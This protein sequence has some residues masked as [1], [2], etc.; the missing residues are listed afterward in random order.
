M[1]HLNSNSE[2]WWR[3][4]ESSNCF[5][6]SIRP[7]NSKFNVLVLGHKKIWVVCCTC[8]SAKGAISAD[9]TIKFR[10]ID[11]LLVQ[12]HCWV[13][14]EE[15]T[16]ESSWRSLSHSCVACQCILEWFE[17]LLSFDLTLELRMLDAWVDMSVDSLAG[18]LIL[19]SIGPRWPKAGVNG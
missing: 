15:V 16:V 14:D 6:R 10:V 9:L 7:C 4:E 2:I 18:F 19:R 17:E 5:V 3:E 1:C 8:C 12:G 13:F 11:L